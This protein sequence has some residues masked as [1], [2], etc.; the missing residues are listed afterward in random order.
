MVEEEEEKD[1]CRSLRSR[2]LLPTRR[3]RRR[4][5]EEEEEIEEEEKRSLLLCWKTHW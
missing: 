5:E 1:G 2:P 3:R 4:E